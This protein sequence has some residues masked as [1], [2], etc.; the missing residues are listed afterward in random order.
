MT[1][2]KRDYEYVLSRD[3]HRPAAR[4]LHMR[5]L[6]SDS[7]DSPFSTAKG[8][9]DERRIR[10]VQDVL[11][12]LESLD[13][14]RSRLF[15]CS[16]EP[17][18][19]DRLRAT[20]PTVPSPIRICTHYCPHFAMTWYAREYPGII[21]ECHYHFDSKEPFKGDFENL[22]RLQTGNRFEIT[23][24]RDAWQLIK[25]ITTTDAV[26]AP[27]LQVADLL[28]W[29]TIRQRTNHQGFFLRGIAVAVKKIIPSAWTHINDNNAAEWCANVPR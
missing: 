21:S 1:A 17:D 12:L 26:I 2:F 7:T 14:T 20:D 29:S 24:N 22:R 16:V 9:N 27:G 19:I 6:R 10:L 8:W 11:E 25:S 5:Q 3:I 23:G 4:Y 13:K 28:A 18:A 15:V